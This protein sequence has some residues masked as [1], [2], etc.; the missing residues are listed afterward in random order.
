[1]EKVSAKM[2]MLM[3]SGTRDELVPPAQM[4]LL[5]NLRESKGGKVRWK[6]VDGGHNDTC[7][8]KGYWEEVEAWLLQEFAM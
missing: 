8:G 2:P 4:E 1:M 3:I 7:V 5:R 6:I